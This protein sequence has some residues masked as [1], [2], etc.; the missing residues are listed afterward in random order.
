[1]EKEI[2]KITGA[3][4]AIGKI[5]SGTAKKSGEPW[6]SQ[7]IVIKPEG[8]WAKPAAFRQYKPEKDL[9][10]EYNLK[11]F[12]EIKFDVESR[13]N[14]GKWYTNLNAW[15]TNKLSDSREELKFEGDKK[16]EV[17]PTAGEDSQDLPF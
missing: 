14:K 2:M 17:P 3:V 15:A 13:E 7:E 1:M 9:T 11:D 10:E 16:D 5:Q 4:I 12:V 6:S 8:K